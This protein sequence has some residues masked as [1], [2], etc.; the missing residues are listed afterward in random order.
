MDMVFARGARAPG[1]AIC[2]ADDL[3]GDGEEDGEMGLAAGGLIEQT[4][5]K[6]PLL[7]GQWADV[8]PLTFNVQLVKA[9]NFNKITGL[10]IPPTPVTSERYEES[11][12][13]FYKMHEEASGI[14]G[15]FDIVKSVAELEG[16][17]ER[18]IKYPL[19][20]IDTQSSKRLRRLAQLTQEVERLRL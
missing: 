15:T 19:V 8:A 18:S 20:Q 14:S 7:P 10:P 6:D 11:G 5:V 1:S 12:L 16:R 13:P 17:E 9:E 3:A 4:I 2:Y